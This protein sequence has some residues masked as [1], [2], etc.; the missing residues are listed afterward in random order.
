MDLKDITETELQFRLVEFFAKWF[1]VYME[2]RDDTGKNRIDL[3]LF[4][5]DD[6]YLLYPIGVEIKKGHI[7][8]G[9]DIGH[10][11]EQAE[12][13]ARTTFGG[14]RAFIFTAP[15]ISGWYLEEGKFMAKHN[16]EDQGYTG[17]HHNVNSFLYKSFMIGELQKYKSTWPVKSNQM[18]LVMNTKEVWNSQNPF[19]FNTAIL[20]LL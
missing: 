4:H 15:Q 14:K 7:K 19:T 17:C 16:V 2:E 8:R 12:R 10:W 20:D 3:L 6:P 18:R 11:C 13:Y 5:K 9:K 1:E